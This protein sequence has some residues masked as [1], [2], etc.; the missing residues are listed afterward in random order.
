MDI[1]IV[2][3]VL[4]FIMVLLLRLIYILSIPYNLLL[5]IRMKEIR[6]QIPLE[7]LRVDIINRDQVIIQPRYPWSTSW[8]LFL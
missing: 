6:D 7:I 2:D 1:I 3:K 8:R 4:I 5:I